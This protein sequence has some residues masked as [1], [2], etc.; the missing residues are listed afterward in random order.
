[1]ERKEENRRGRV[2]RRKQG[3]QEGQRE[4]RGKEGKER[5][6]IISRMAGEMAKWTKCL[7]DKHEFGLPAL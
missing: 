2:R 4:E 5:E 6:D 1:M 3:G 7:S